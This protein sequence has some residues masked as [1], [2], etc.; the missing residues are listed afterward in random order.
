MLSRYAPHLISNAEEKCHRFLNG[1]KDVIRQPLVPF[2]IEDYPTLVERARRIEMDMQATQKR[3]DFQKRKM[4]DRS[5]LSQ[6]IQSS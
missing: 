3:R 6:M 2:G 1:L 4:E 5:I